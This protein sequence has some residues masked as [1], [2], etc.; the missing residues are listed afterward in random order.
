MPQQNQRYKVD[1][2]IFSID[3]GGYEYRVK[4]LDT[5]TKEIVDEWNSMFQCYNGSGHLTKE[6]A[7][8]NVE[9]IVQDVEDG[10]PELWF[11]M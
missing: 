6:N 1:H 2:N 4:L 5:K 10:K 11:N 9:Q 8:A 7:E 3:S